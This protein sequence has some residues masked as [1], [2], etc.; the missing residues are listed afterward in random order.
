VE[1]SQGLIERR[2]KGVV[3][4]KEGVNVDVVGSSVPAVYVTWATPLFHHPFHK[5]NPGRAEFV[6][7]IE[8][9]QTDR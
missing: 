4:Y 3:Y 7:I 2:Q 1:F 5:L 9:N 8:A 6:R